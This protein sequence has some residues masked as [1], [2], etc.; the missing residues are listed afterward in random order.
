[1]HT[2][3]CDMACIPLPTMIEQKRSV[4][5]SNPLGKRRVH[6]H[7]VLEAAALGSV[8][9]FYLFS[10]SPYYLPAAGCASFIIS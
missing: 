10:V 2:Q 1:M 8:Y 4:C 3:V 5:H 7:L 9:L 6:L